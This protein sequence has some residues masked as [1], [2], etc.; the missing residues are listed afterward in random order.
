VIA[1]NVADCFSTRNYLGG[2]GF[3]CRWCSSGAHQSRQRCCSGR[4][5]CSG[6]RQRTL[7]LFGNSTGSRNTASGDGA[8]YKN[9]TG[10]FNNAVGFQLGFDVT[11]GSNDIESVSRGGSDSNTIRLGTQGTQ[12]ATYIAGISQLNWGNGA[13]Q[14]VTRTY[15]L[16]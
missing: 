4:W 8:L 5:C 3:H 13:G 6:G 11:G 14:K 16:C 12:K 9:N 7:V 10:Q 2:K 15:W 1:A